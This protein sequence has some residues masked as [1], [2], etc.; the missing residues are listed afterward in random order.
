MHL[1]RSVTVWMNAVLDQVFP[2]FIRDSRWFI[3]S[4]YWL[5]FR[6]CAKQFMTFKQQAPGMTPAEYAETYATVD[7]VLY[8]MVWRETDASE[9][10]IEAIKKSI[11][12]E[13]ILEVGSGRGHVSGALAEKYQVTGFDMQ[14]SDTARTRYPK[15]HF[16]EGL[17]EHLPFPDAA[18]DTVVCAHTLEHVP[19]FMQTIRELR[20]VTRQRLIIVV[21]K[22]R[23]YK[24]TF[25]LHL[26][27]FPYPHSL[28]TILNEPGIKQTCEVVGGDLF[29]VQD[30]G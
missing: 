8:R 29:Y 25:D 13:T 21:P 19:Y 12:G 18:F 24:Y 3:P 6:K 23:P 2:P 4:A 1:P 27:F 17:A 5:F 26:H 30:M 15:V 22:Q 20:R 16:V 28:L 11:V 7:P 9:A 14:I 10:S